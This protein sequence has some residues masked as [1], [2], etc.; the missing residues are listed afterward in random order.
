VAETNAPALYVLFPPRQDLQRDDG[1]RL[2]DDWASVENLFT[3]YKDLCKE[4]E[5]PHM[6]LESTTIDARV[7]EV[8][9]AAL[10]ATGAPIATAITT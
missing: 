9:G 7:R 5:L 2:S 6:V 3:V 10:I 8:I 4:H 1:V